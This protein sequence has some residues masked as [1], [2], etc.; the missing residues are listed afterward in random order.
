[1]RIRAMSLSLPF[2]AASLSQNQ[3]RRY[4]RVRDSRAPRA[5]GGER[6]TSHRLLPPS[7]PHSPLLLH[8]QD[9]TYPRHVPN[10][11]NSPV[12]LI[13]NAFVSRGDASLRRLQNVIKPLDNSS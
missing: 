8:P 1:M 10:S 13:C 6:Q 12:G 9:S 2:R 4:D 5:S 7:A 3:G 11:S